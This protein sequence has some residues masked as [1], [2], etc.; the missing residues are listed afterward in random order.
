MAQ[1]IFEVGHRAGRAER[2]TD[3]GSAHCNNIVGATCNRGLRLP[4]TTALTHPTLLYHSRHDRRGRRA[5]RPGDRSREGRER[6]EVVWFGMCGCWLVRPHD[7]VTA[8][9]VYASHLHRTLVLR[10]MPFGSGMVTR[11]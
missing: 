8:D 4:L 1:P 2:R 11:N 3:A 5:G 9:C 6:K 7:V 10:L